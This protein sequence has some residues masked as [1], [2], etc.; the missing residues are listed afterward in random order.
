MVGRYADWEHDRDCP[1][2]PVYSRFAA[3]GPLTPIDGF[4]VDAMGP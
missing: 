2:C 1:I 4:I 3:G